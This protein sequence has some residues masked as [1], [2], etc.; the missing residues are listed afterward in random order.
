M[1]ETEIVDGDWRWFGRCQISTWFATCVAKEHG[2]FNF[3]HQD[4]IDCS[5]VLSKRSP[6]YTAQ[7]WWVTFPSPNVRSNISLVRINKDKKRALQVLVASS[8]SLG[9]V[10]EF[11]YGDS[12][13]AVRAAHAAEDLA[14]GA[15]GEHEDLQDQLMAPKQIMFHRQFHNVWHS[16]AAYSQLWKSMRFQKLMR[17]AWGD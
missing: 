13:S 3:L 14:H 5:P 16:L 9:A 2:T 10:S 8:T 1:Y 4:R 7:D 11:F 17:L 12:L 15:H 6:K